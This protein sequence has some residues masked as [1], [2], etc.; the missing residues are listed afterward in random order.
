M[1][2]QKLK[3]GYLSSSPEVAAP[4][5]RAP[6]GLFGDGLDVWKSPSDR[7]LEKKGHY[8]LCISPSHT[9]G[10]QGPVLNLSTRLLK[11]IE[12]RPLKFSYVH[13]EEASGIE[14]ESQDLYVV[15]QKK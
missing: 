12:N 11:C 4:C 1:K 9:I 15:S 3:Y 14:I 2:L 8:S 13:F 5:F 10:N 6:S 7:H